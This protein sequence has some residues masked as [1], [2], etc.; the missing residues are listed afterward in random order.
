[1]NKIY[2]NFM[3][4]WK[5]TKEYFKRLFE[6]IVKL[7]KIIFF[8]FIRQYMEQIFFINNLNSI[9]QILITTNLITEI[10]CCKRLSLCY[11]NDGKI[12][13]FNK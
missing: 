4:F 1:M 10:F 7:L 5:R 11:N 8:I 13:K 9:M 2:S 3:E 12:H 6:A